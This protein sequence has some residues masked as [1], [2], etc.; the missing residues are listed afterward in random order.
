MFSM[1]RPVCVVMMF[2][3]VEGNAQNPTGD[4]L[5][6]LRGSGTGFVKC[7][8]RFFGGS[9]R[10]LEVVVTKLTVQIGEDGTNDDVQVKIC[11]DT[12]NVCCTSPPL[13]KTFSDDWSRNDREEWGQRYL[14]ECG[15]KRFV[16]ERGLNIDLVKQGKDDLDVTSIVIDAESG[17]EKNKHPEQFECG[18]QS[19]VGELG[20]ETQLCGTYQY[21]YERVK[22]ITV[23]MGNEGTND[24]VR[25]DI[26]SDVDSLCCRAKL[27]TLLRDDWSRNDVEVW[28]ESDLGECRGVEYQVAS[29]LHLTL[30]KDGEDDLTVNKIKIETEDL[31]E[32]LTVY[33][34]K[35]FTL[36][37][38]GKNCTASRC[39]QSK[40]CSKQ[41]QNNANLPTNLPTSQPD[42]PPAK[43][44]NTRPAGG[45]LAQAGF[46]LGART[47]TTTMKTTTRTTRAPFFG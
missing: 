31:E 41:N 4:G 9:K 28:T 44:S 2:W 25:V 13:K 17:E 22:K 3:L 20:A 38:M 45:L 16:V 30:V 12:D 23:T 46:I 14:G 35:G 8:G 26:C 40:L 15:E 32:S 21:N 18:E 7:G 1:F 19:I 36:R 43:P 6:G 29:G 33:D 39:Q 34:C 24:D 47:T 42:L 10:C 5:R 27:S 11:S 37:R